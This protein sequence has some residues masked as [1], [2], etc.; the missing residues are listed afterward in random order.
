MMMPNMVPQEKVELIAS[1]NKTIILGYPSTRYDATNRAERFEVWATDK[2]LPFFPY[3]QTGPA[4]FG[5]RMLEDQ[6]PDWLK[7]RGLFPLNASLRTE[8]G[9]DRFHFEVLSI[10]AENII[11]SEG[12]LFQPPAEYRETEPLPF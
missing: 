2:L 3:T 12:K 7:S 9:P 4:R 10:K 6:W 1:T 5:P 8:N 11:D